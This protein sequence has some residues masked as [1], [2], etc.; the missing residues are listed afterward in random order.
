M[1]FLA[2]GLQRGERP[3]LVDA[4]ETRISHHVRG[5]DRGEPARRT[6]L[7]VH[8]LVSASARSN[9]P[10]FMPIV[11]S[12]CLACPASERELCLMTD[13]T[14]K[15]GSQVCAGGAKRALS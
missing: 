14:R 3:F 7:F 15:R 12:A 6:G 9:G 11:P 2:V 1:S 8:S 10:K 13:F 4:H 5:E